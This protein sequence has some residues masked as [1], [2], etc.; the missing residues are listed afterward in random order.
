M[1]PSRPEFVGGGDAPFRMPFRLGKSGK[2]NALV[3][4]FAVIFVLVSV[5]YFM[6]LEYVEPNEFGIKEVQ[7]ALFGSRGIQETEYGPGFYFVIPY[8][9][10]M[11]RLPRNVKVLELTEAGGNRVTGSRGR[12]VFREPPAKIQTSDGFFVDLDVSIM[13]RIVDPYLVIKELGPGEQ[14][15]SLGLQ[16]NAVSALKTTL[17]ELA[18]EEFYNSPL[19]VAKA[20]EARELLDSAMRERGIAVDHVLVRYFKYTDSIQKNIEAK[21]LEDQLVFTNQSLRKV[22][23]EERK[24]NKVT[25]EGEM[26]VVIAHQEGEAYRVKKEADKDLYARKKT[27]DADLLVKL[28]EAK[29]TELNNEAMQVLGADRKVAM[30]MAE[31]LKGLD[32]IVLPSGGE[33]DLNPLDLEQVLQMFGVAD[34]GGPGRGTTVAEGTTATISAP[35]LTVESTNTVEM[36]VVQ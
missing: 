30:A 34:Y 20:E 9:Q 21:K 27:A 12:S 13:F 6:F 29:A 31:V 23:E 26:Q 33:N 19:R 5:C 15:F 10:K 28:A 25:K 22:A 32:V 8:M 36:E 16:P 2:V 7:I 14:Y 4:L 35:M 11:H 24:L 17:G 18:P 3:G 1:S